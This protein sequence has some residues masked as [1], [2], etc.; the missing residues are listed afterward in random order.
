M[1]MMN[2][3][4]YEVLLEPGSK[5]F[6][7]TDGATE[8]TNAQGEFFGTERIID[9]LRACEER[10]ASEIVKTVREQV[11]KFTGSAPQFDDLTML[12]LQYNK[13]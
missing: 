10:P 6:V 8:A 12:C 1:D 7:Y 3:R 9:T 13:R 4:E 2:Y 11:L 5:L